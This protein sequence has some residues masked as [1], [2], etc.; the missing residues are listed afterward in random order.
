[1]PKGYRKDGTKLGFQKGYKPTEEHTEKRKKALMG[2]PSPMKGKKF[3]K[4]HCRKIGLSQSGFKHWNWKGGLIIKNCIICNKEFR[5]GYK[6]KNTAKF[7]SYKCRG[8]NQRKK[9]L[10]EECKNKISNANKGKKRSYESI[11]KM[12]KNRKSF[13]GKNNPKWKGGKIISRGY[14]FIYMPEHPFANECYIPEHR[15]VM[16]QMIGRYLKPEERVH[17]KG[18]EYP[19]NSIKNKQ[20]NR[21]ENLQLFKNVWEHCKYHK[22]LRSCDC[23]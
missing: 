22:K 18:I 3:S 15:F 7:C 1:M 8:I 5:V 13:I 17:H 14:V 11:Q 21:P 2:R 16:E 10:S 19:I 23:P 12:I 4:E 9:P 6:R 20:D